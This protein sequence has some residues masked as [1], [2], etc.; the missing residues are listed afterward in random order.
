MYIITINSAKKAKNQ[1]EI[2]AQLLEMDFPDIP[3]LAK[4]SDLLYNK[5]GD[6]TVSSISVNK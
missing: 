4:F 1:R 2:Q 3:K 5:F 6:K